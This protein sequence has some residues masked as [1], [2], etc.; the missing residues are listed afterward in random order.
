M[1]KIHEIVQGSVHLIKDYCTGRNNCVSCPIRNWCESVL[2]YECDP[3]QWD[4]TELFE[5]DLNG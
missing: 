1:N 2:K 4:L 5:G 3:Y